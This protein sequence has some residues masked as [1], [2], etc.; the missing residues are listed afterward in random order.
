LAEERNANFF[1]CSTGDARGELGTASP[2]EALDGALTPMHQ[3]QCRVLI[4]IEN[5]KVVGLLTVG[6][7]GELLALEAAGRQTGALAA[8]AGGG[9]SR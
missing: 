5:E 9:T 2:S 3:G 4:V 6:N 7:I 1:R 8:N